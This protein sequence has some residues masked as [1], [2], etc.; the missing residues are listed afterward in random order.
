V[1]RVLTL[2]SYALHNEVVIFPAAESDLS[3]VSTGLG[4]EIR[5]NNLQHQ[6]INNLRF[7]NLNN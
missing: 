7:K 5:V 3:N 6:F 4:F 1:G 2:L